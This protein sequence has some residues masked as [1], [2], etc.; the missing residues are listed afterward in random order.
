M[1]KKEKSLK[2][3][4]A[5]RA[6]AEL[7]KQVDAMNNRN[8]G[9]VATGEVK[10]RGRKRKEPVPV[11]EA[12]EQIRELTKKAMDNDKIPNQQ[13]KADCGKPRLSLVPMKILEAIARIREY[14]NKKYHDPDNWKTVEVE[15]YRDAAMRHM[16]AYI[17][18]PSGVDEE[19]GMPHLWHLACNIAFIVELEDLKMK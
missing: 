3:R 9:N 7:K 1:M 13:A 19:S 6:E 10:R 11:D 12:I 8:L 14:G 4:I 2:T 17:E 18:D 5:E 15:R 16:V